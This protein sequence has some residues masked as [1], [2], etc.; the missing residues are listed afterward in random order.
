VIRLA[1]ILL[2]AYL[3]SYL[4]FRTFNQEIWAAD[5]QSWLIFPEGRV[6]Y[7]VWRPLSWADSRLSG[8]RV[9]IGPHAT[10]D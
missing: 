10:T 7:Y 6:L 5:G 1:L 4:V 8:L 9:H 3:A 2:A